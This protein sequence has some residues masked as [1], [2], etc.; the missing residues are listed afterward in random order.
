MRALLLAVAVAPL[1]CAST[2]PC[3]QPR[4]ALAAPPTPLQTHY[5]AAL[6]S[7]KNPTPDKVYRQLVPIVPENK[8]LTWKDFDG[9]AYVLTATYVSTFKWQ[10]PSVG[11]KPYDTGPRDTWVS[12]APF[13]QQLCRDPA[14]R[15]DDVSMRLKQ[16]LGL[17]PGDQKIG[18]VELWVRPADLFRPCPDNEISDTECGLNLPNDVEP[19]YRKWFNDLRA[20]QYFVAK[21]P[22]WPGWPWT[23]LGYTFDWHDLAKP[24]GVSEYVIKANSTIRV[25][26]VIPTDEYC[27]VDGG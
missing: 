11:D 4:P 27:G 21:V 19:W 10:Q 12:P 17:P 9:E 24:I 1:A 6:D 25:R 15:G 23:Q 18:F 22:A 13:V 2:A 7:A 16:L 26:A 8:Q 5:Q 14:W 20:Q 3:P